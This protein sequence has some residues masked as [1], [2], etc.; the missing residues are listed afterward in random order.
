MVLC[1]GIGYSW[2]ANEMVGENEVIKNG[3]WD[4]LK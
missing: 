3:W 1:D 2:K 4:E